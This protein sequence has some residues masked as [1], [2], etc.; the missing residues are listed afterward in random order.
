MLPEH[1]GIIGNCRFSALVGRTALALKLHCF[2]DAGAII[3][4]MT[5]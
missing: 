3:A 1:L 5:S 2:K 4:A